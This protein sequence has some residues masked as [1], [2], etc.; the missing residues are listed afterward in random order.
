MAEAALTVADLEPAKLE[1][2]GSSLSKETSEKETVSS[3]HQSILKK[4]KFSE[5]KK[6]NFSDPSK[7]SV[8]EISFKQPVESESINSKDTLEKPLPTIDSQ[9][10]ESLKTLSMLNSEGL[11][12]GSLP[13]VQSASDLRWKSNTITSKHLP[14]KHFG[15]SASEI[16]RQ[17]LNSFYLNNMKKHNFLQEFNLK[18]P[19]PLVHLVEGKQVMVVRSYGSL[20]N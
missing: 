2:P 13:P 15:H 5:G 8:H 17:R 6:V 11:L 20:N 1:T 10:S 4:S 18:K 7:N 19:E 9:G 12:K 3:F 16:F 14:G